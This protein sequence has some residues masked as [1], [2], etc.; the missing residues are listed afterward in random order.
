MRI[1][2]ERVDIISMSEWDISRLNFFLS[3]G[4]VSHTE[5]IDGSIEI[6][7]PPRSGGHLPMFMIKE[8]PE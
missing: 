6:V 5:H 1:R 4:G 2:L 3:L 8:C 7:R